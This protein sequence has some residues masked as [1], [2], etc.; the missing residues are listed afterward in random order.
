MT[1]DD[2]QKIPTPTAPPPSESSR[3]APSH[4]HDGA[5]SFVAP[6]FASTT[7]QLESD[8][9]AAPHFISAE[10]EET[11]ETMEFCRQLVEQVY[12]C[13]WFLTVIENSTFIFFS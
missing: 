3:C 4:D 9:T 12:C 5:V 11:A 7:K 8:T 6:S 2:Q 13:F 1:G 10:E